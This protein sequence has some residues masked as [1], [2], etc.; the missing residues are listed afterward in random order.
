MSS[1]NRTVEFSFITDQDTHNFTTV[2]IGWD[3][4]DQSIKRSKKT[5]GLVLNISQNL[6][7]LNEE[8]QFL[9]STLLNKGQDYKIKVVRKEKEDNSFKVSHSGYI[10]LKTLK[11]N[12]TTAT[13]DF[14]EN[15]FD[16]IFRDNLR[17]KF[18]LD[19]E[20]DINGDAIP[21]LEKHQYAHRARKIFLDSKLTY[22]EDT[23]DFFSDR[24]RDSLTVT[25]RVK[26]DFR[27]DEETVS[28]FDIMVFNM[29]TEIETANIFHF[30]AARD[31]T[32]KLNIQCEIEHDN[33]YNQS[34]FRIYRYENGTDLDLVEFINLG[35]VYSNQGTV[36][37][38][39]IIDIEL[40]RGQSLVFG[41][42]IDYQGVS[43]DCE[44]R[45]NSCNIRQTEDSLYTPIDP[46]DRFYDCITYKEAFARVI[47]ILDPTVEF[48]SNLLDTTWRDLLLFNGATARHVVY[49][50]EE[51]EV[52]TLPPIATTSFEELYKGLFKITPVAYA[53]FTEGSKTV[54]QLEDIDYYFDR[55][56]VL[57]L[58]KLTD[59]EYSI[60]DKKTFGSIQ[61]GNSKSGTNEEI[62]GLQVT[63]ILKTYQLPIKT[64]D[65]VYEAISPFKE[66]PTELELAYREQHK[67]NPTT[68]HK[69]DKNIFVIDAELNFVA[70]VPLYVSHEYQEHFSTVSG[71]YDKDSLTNYRLLPMQCLQRHAKN[72][73]QAY[74]KDV[75]DNYDVV[76]S[77][78]DES[79]NPVVT[80]IGGT[81]QEE[82]GSVNMNTLDDPMYTNILIKGE[83][84]YSRGLRDE[85]NGSDEKPNYYKTFNWI[86]DEGTTEN[87]F[88]V[89]I[90]IKD[91]ITVELAER[92]R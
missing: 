28:V 80:P 42:Y 81:A 32:L 78:P 73:K 35:N 1:F 62:Y 45:V 31:K 60:N 72:F 53:I 18:S 88:A 19:R 48:R 8:R 64:S 33:P 20:T 76:F 69:D 57:N 49:T 5:D 68:D 4:V 24:N 86:S 92:F 61:I 66:D 89:D 11:W 77:S 70:G 40:L 90:N 85:I 34:Q 46:L 38:D 44:G 7:F 91:K 13:C 51:T 71:V 14:V 15:Y 10:S 79:I 30:D 21:P 22:D 43:T 52:E 16:G 47:Q 67:E 37:F 65:V 3:E 56:E 55:Q 87:A 17:E 9:V 25:P 59:I 36:T 12:K 39:E 54:I 50:D 63:H 26:I 82:N 75:Y 84:P 83:V 2:P 27:S 41:Y 74:S 29:I 58:G 23:G 6:E